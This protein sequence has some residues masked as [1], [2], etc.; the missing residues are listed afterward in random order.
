MLCSRFQVLY[1]TIHTS[2]Y[3]Q[4]EHHGLLASYLL[5][6]RYNFRQS[7]MTSSDANNTVFNFYIVLIYHSS[8][9]L[10]T[11][12][13]SILSIILKQSKMKVGVFF[14]TQCRPSITECNTVTTL[15]KPKLS[16]S[17]LLKC[18]TT[19]SGSLKLLSHK[20]PQEVWDYNVSIDMMYRNALD[21]HCKTYGFTRSWRRA[22]CCFSSPRVM[23]WC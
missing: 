14:W 6:T 22:E 20:P 5:S 17:H 9:I 15:L 11:C 4:K 2:R 21:I 8:R 16:A 1:N 10:A 7:N 23:N 13:V 18:L 12:F 3:S 19:V